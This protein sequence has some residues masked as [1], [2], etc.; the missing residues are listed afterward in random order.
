MGLEP[1]SQPMPVFSAASSAPIDVLSIV[2]S[3]T[4]STNSGL[5]SSPMVFAAA[6]QQLKTEY[7]SDQLV[8]LLAAS[9]PDQS[10]AAAAAAAAVAANAFP[11]LNGGTLFRPNFTTTSPMTFPG[12]TALL[13]Q[14]QSLQNGK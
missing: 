14:A 1:I 9:Q 2:S 7:K 6:P 11:T 3:V 12:T 8:S 5:T 4:S 13:Q 10:A